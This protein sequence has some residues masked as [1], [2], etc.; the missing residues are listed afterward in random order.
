MKRSHTAEEKNKPQRL[1]ERDVGLLEYL[2]GDWP[3][4]QGIIKQR[5]S[6]FL[7]HE[8]A[9]DGSVVHINSLA[10]PGGGQCAK[11]WAHEVLQEVHDA[12]ADEQEK[13]AARVSVS[14][15]PENEGPRDYAPLAPYFDEQA[16]ASLPSLT[17]DGCVVTKP[18]ESK[19]ARTEVHQL[20]RT[21]SNGTLVS[22]AITV[23]GSPAISVKRASG[24]RGRDVRPDPTS[25]AQSA[26]PYI[27]FT[28]QKTNRDSQEAMQWLARSLRLGGPRGNA[29]ATNMLS[30]AGTKDRRAVTVQRVA[31]RRGRKTLEDVWRMANHIDMPVG[32]RDGPRRSV[33]LAATTRAERGLRV[34]DLRYADEPLNLGDL[35]GN[36]FT[37]TL[38]DVRWAGGD[39]TADLAAELERRVAAV[40]ANGYINYFGMQRFGTGAVPT[41][42]IG[43]QIL[44][45]DYA[46]ALDLLL[47][48]HADDS[49][50]LTVREAKDAYA[51]GRY[52][53]A[54]RL[55]PRSC[56]AERAV[57]EKIKSPGWQ[58]ADAL[59]AFQN[60]PRTLR[61]MYVHA[62]QSYLWNKLV[63]ERI[64]RHGARPV[65]GDMLSD[66]TV[67][68]AASAATADLADIQM[69]MPG[70][71]V[72]LDGWLA[73]LYTELLAA[74]NLTPSSL[75][76]SRQP[77]YRL[78][79]S[80]RHMIQ[81]PTALS[82][83]VVPYTDSDVPLCATDEEVLLDEMRTK[84]GQE[85]LVAP[86]AAAAPDASAGSALL[87]LKLVF[88]LPPSAYATILLREVLRTDTSS[89]VHKQLTQ[90]TSA[91][92]ADAAA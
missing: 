84:H 30:V 1:T 39:A 8:I 50:E 40:A 86:A 87:A 9:P 37:V 13:S 5:Y 69:P 42:S 92:A 85:P 44:R 63:S 17:K 82:C 11:R 2:N 36:Q 76:S 90:S 51:A 29:S 23:D 35:A 60:I 74:D 73:E 78:R 15:R 79:G 61:L 49:D 27:H 41:H 89:H 32:P 47:A 43:I 34:A 56:V 91:D 53:D 6:D 68:D 83:T 33:L 57:L 64:R 45:G 66:G 14:S 38:R 48:P 22:E 81:R 7:V 71:D 46:K 20:I 59:G 12:A 58:T 3:P 70:S 16:L 77:E 80:Y 65:A 25:E 10:P 88:Q 72:Q 75:S 31:L 54:Y 67:L 4:V 26:P 28:L 55:F 21:L 24:R 52:E 19:T 18:L 62:Y